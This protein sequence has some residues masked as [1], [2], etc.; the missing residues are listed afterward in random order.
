MTVL[1][2]RIPSFT[3]VLAILLLT[4]AIAANPVEGLFGKKSD[5]DALPLERSWLST[6]GFEGARRI[7]ETREKTRRKSRRV[8]KGMIL[9]NS[10]MLLH[11][12]L[13]LPSL[14]SSM[15]ATKVIVET[16]NDKVSDGGSLKAFVSVFF[17]GMASLNGWLLK[18][19]EALSERGPDGNARPKGTFLHAC[20]LMGSRGME[21]FGG[22]LLAFIYLLSL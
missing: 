10:V 15:I 11:G 1:F 9:G 8:A 2:Q 12:N 14:A 6:G 16:N 17:S 21:L 4:I 3:V 20:L 13:A 19:V 18:R 7:E 5:E 22:T